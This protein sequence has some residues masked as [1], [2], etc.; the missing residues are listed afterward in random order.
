MATVDSQV[1]DE[2]AIE[3]G[4]LESEASLLTSNDVAGDLRYEGDVPE[5]GFGETR[6]T[7]FDVVS[8]GTTTLRGTWTFDLDR[9]IQGPDSG[10]DIWWEQ[11]TSTERQMTPR[12]T[13]G[14]VNIG[15]V[16]YGSLAGSDL[17]R[18]SYGTTPIDG[19]DD[20]SN[21]LVNDDV[22][23]VSTTA[24]NYAKVR[25]VQYGYDM[26]IQW[27]TYRPV[28]VSS[29]TTTL[30]GTWTFD[31]DRGIQGPDSGA[32][33][34]WEQQTSTERQ[35]TPRGSAEI[36][37]I[38]VVDYDSLTVTDL[39]QL[40]Y[41][42]TPIDGDDDASNQLVDGDVFAVSTTGGNYAKVRVIQYGYNIE[43]Q[44]ATYESIAAAPSPTP[45]ATE[46]PTPTATDEPT[47]T[48]SPS[49]TQSPTGT[50]EPTEIVGN[51]GGGPQFPWL[52][53]TLGVLGFVALAGG[54]YFLTRSGRKSGPSPGDTPAEPVPP[55]PPAP[56]WSGLVIEEIRRQGDT[57]DV[58]VR[59]ATPETWTAAGK[60]IEDARGNRNHLPETLSIAP[61]ATEILRFDRGDDEIFAS[62]EG[63]DVLLHT[64]E[65]EQTIL[66]EEPEE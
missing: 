46:A 12:G 48:P 65:G 27:T 14:I 26:D 32:D 53:L 1:R 5:Q 50:P 54:G 43:I 35:M 64:D 63:E 59:N 9:G 30:R 47:L 15:V 60:T 23:A 17:Q 57:T 10:A 51:G 13:A 6:L 41:G 33:I 24:G 37:N 39:Q 16:D 22:F 55:V 25:V 49:P 28:P 11:Q 62:T 18:L 40:S 31:L 45:T 58:V 44:W 19:D 42:T 36:V 7:E 2:V 4:V 61:G 56:E 34:W 20:A 21:Q 52:W 66:W 29:G 8:S 38:G 3:P